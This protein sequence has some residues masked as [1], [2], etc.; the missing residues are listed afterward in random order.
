MKKR[1]LCIALLTIILAGCT[2]APEQPGADAVLPP[3]GMLPNCVNSDSGTG[4]SAIAPLQATTE[5]W[6][7]LKRW[8][9]QQGDWTITVETADF[10]QAVVKTPLMQF[11]DD[12]QLAFK[13]QASDIQVRSSSRLGISDMGAN[14]RR[15][16][17]L[18]A[19]LAS[20][21]AAAAD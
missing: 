13:Q 1:H 14:R 11:R 15:I 9:A 12:V 21:A 5:Q 2:S 19:H 18:R 4:G 6:Q 16:E 20:E 7:A 8:L 3:C 10:V 17:S